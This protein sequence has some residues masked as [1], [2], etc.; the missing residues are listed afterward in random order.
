MDLVVQ[1]HLLRLVFLVNLED[2]E[3]LEDPLGLVNLECL[4]RLEDLAGQQFS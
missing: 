4:E 1:Y 2:L 3:F